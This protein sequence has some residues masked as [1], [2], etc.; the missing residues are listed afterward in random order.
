M[1][2]MVEALEGGSRSSLEQEG[3]GE[4]TEG[5]KMRMESEKG[6][7]WRQGGRVSA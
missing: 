1:A 5:E 6:S 7:S 4:G 2:G 3:P